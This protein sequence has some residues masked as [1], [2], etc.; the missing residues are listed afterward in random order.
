MKKKLMII[1]ECASM[2]THYQAV[3][4]TKYD[5]EYHI[6]P[7]DA[8]RALYASRNAYDLIITEYSVSN[9]SAEQILKLVRANNIVIP[10][11]LATRIPGV[12]KSPFG[13]FI[14]KSKGLDSCVIDLLLE[15]PG[16][17]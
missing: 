9:I 14:D 5:I 4:G 11:V 3:Y 6:S 15:D 16:T 13:G 8:M 2:Q 10:I 7:V 12:D 17:S 1:D